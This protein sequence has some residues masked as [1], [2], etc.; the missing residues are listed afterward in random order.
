MKDKIKKLLW[1]YSY[2]DFRNGNISEAEK[3]EEYPD[4]ITDKLLSL[5][6]S[7]FLELIGED[8]K[9]Q[10]LEKPFNA[11]IRVTRMQNQA[12]N[13]LRQELRNKLKE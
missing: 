1:Q 8:E 3:Y 4:F 12:T 2:G 13:D 7:E 6:K 11:T 5:F 10:P 9:I